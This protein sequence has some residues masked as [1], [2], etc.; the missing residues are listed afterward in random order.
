V[1]GAEL[2]KIKIP[3]WDRRVSLPN[4]RAST[5][6]CRLICQVTGAELQKIK[7]PIWDR[8]VARS[9]PWLANKQKL[10]IG[11]S[12][13]DNHTDVTVYPAPAGNACESS[14]INYNLKHASIEEVYK[15]IGCV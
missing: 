4:V 11:F 15:A 14:S 13:R 7:I 10:I 1:T 9:L 3:V 5:V 8:R 6:F 12:P 2:Q